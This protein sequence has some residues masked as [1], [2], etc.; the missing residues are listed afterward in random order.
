MRLRSSKNQA[1][2]SR[3]RSYLTTHIVESSKG[4]PTQCNPPRVEEP[5]VNY[6]N[7]T[8]GLPSPGQPRYPKPRAEWRPPRTTAGPDLLPN[9]TKEVDMK[10]QSPSEP[11]QGKKKP[12]LSPTREGTCL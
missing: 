2:S 5:A 9:G 8:M 1:D 7:P 10:H 11:Q 12:R 6:A 3:P 4:T